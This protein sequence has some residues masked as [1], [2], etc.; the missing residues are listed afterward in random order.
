MNNPCEF[1]LCGTDPEPETR[2]T[3][4][5]RERH[6]YAAP[7]ETAELSLESLRFLIDLYPQPVFITDPDD[8]TIIAAN[9]AA[10]RG[11]PGKQPAGQSTAHVLCY[12]QK[13]DEMQEMVY[14][15][16]T[17]LVLERY[18]FQWGD[19]SCNIIILKTP[20][21]LPEKSEIHTARDMV[22]LVLHRLRSPLTG[23]QGYIDLL[24]VDQDSEQ[25][26]K[27]AGK[28]RIGMDQLNAML[29]E[30]ESLHTTDWDYEPVNLRIESLLMELTGELSENDRER[31]ELRRGKQ[32]RM[33]RGNR[34]KLTRLLKLLLNNALEHTSGKN[35]P[36]IITVDSPLKI[37]ITN[38]GSPIPEYLKVRMF[39]P[40]ITDKARSMGLGLPIA[41]MIAQQM[42]I[43]IIH[44]SN[45]A[46][47]GIT[48]S[49]LLP[50]DCLCGNR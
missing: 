7:M 43:T 11:C 22:A 5:R 18:P 32:S 45:S 8:L 24:S 15:G 44:T 16:R 4:P 50:P 9:E 38:Y 28:L 46:E 37:S 35:Q 49:L 30:L 12:E 25:I 47:D 23:M 19:T 33:I 10:C 14:F 36:I 3:G 21:G 34:E 20:P 27:R 40:F 29:N 26:S 41:N 13:L 1:S 39:S 17:W 2:C 48:F 6:A 42:G 31:I